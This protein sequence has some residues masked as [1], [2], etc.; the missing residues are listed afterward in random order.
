MQVTSTKMCSSV[1]C[2]IPARYGKTEAPQ[3]F[4]GRGAP[5]KLMH[6]CLLTESGPLCGVVCG[7]SSDF[8]HIF[9]LPNI[10]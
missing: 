7:Q 4:R 1:G 3:S 5:S 9:V 8:R 10:C 2:V 6:L